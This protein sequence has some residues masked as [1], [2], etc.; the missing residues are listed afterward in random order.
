MRRAAQKRRSYDTVW[1]IFRLWRRQG[2]WYWPELFGRISGDGSQICRRAFWRRVRIQGRNN[3]HHCRQD[4]SY[5]CKKILWEKGNS[6]PWRWTKAYFKGYCRCEENDR[7][8]SW[9]N[10]SVPQDHGYTW[11]YSCS[12]PGWQ[13]GF[14]HYNHTLW[15]PFYTWQPAKAGHTRTRWP[16]NNKNAGGFDRYKR[17]GDSSWR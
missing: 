5:V 14:R 7:A 16:I 12:A 1:N 3:R 9:R 6:G 8:A 11:L 4:G 10:H 2:S 13:K 15:F 17:L